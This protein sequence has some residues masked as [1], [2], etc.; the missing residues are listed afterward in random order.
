MHEKSQRAALFAQANHP[1][2]PLQAGRYKPGVF[3]AQGPD[4]GS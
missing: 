4:T 3:T 1:R 2:Y